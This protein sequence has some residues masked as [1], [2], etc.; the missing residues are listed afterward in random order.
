MFAA[1]V[2]SEKMKEGFGF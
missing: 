1:R 2:V